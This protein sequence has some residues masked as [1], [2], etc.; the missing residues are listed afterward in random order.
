MLETGLK[1]L[2]P[3]GLASRVE[4]WRGDFCLLH[5]LQFQ[6]PLEEVSVFHPSV[7]P[8]LGFIVRH[9]AR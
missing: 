2:R 1:T 3:S 4:I 5:K 6:C 9:L 7:L 8:E